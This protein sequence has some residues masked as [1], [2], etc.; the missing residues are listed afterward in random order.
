MLAGKAAQQSRGTWKPLERLFVVKH[1]YPMQAGRVH[2]WL[3][4]ND[5]Y[6]QMTRDYDI[7]ITRAM[8]CISDLTFTLFKHKSNDRCRSMFAQQKRKSLEN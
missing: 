1:K 5:I 7:N 6:E 8:L 2:V 4:H 3:P